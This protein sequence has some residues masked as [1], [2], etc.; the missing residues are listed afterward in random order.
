MW[1]SRD[2]LVTTKAWTHTVGI[3]ILIKT[4][5]RKNDTDKSSEESDDN[6]K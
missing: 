5:E 4:N 1:L 2:D 6:Y 3:G